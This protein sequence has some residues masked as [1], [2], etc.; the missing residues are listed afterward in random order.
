M[1]AIVH[2]FGDKGGETDGIGAK[3]R[4]YVEGGIIEEP[5]MGWQKGGNDSELVAAKR[6]ITE[7]QSAL[8]TI[9]LESI[10]DDVRDENNDKAHN[11]VMG[12][13]VERGA[14][15]GIIDLSWESKRANVGVVVHDEK[16]RVLDYILA[17]SSE[18]AFRREIIHVGGDGEGGN[19]VLWQHYKGTTVVEYLLRI[20]VRNQGSGWCIVIKSEDEKS[21]PKEA[22]MKLVK[23][24]TSTNALRARVEG[25]I[26][27]A[28]YEYGQ[29]A[30]TLV[31]MLEVEEVEGSASGTPG[32]P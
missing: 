18:G 27:L 16:E 32:S 14:V 3:G 12:K 6:Q 4:S 11:D 20:H 2:A 29:T 22:K 30:L 26:R 19:I 25:E 13:L 24:A 28:S 17:G 21:L 15:E 10:P 9:A 31:G 5:L 1:K 8:K 23:I 7:L